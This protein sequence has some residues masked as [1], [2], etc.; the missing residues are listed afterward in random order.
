MAAKDCYTENPEF[1][2]KKEYTE[3][4]DIEQ[5]YEVFIVI[6]KKEL[7]KWQVKEDELKESSRFIFFTKLEK[8][9]KRFKMFGPNYAM[10][11]RIFTDDEELYKLAT[12]NDN[13]VVEDI[14]DSSDEEAST[15]ATVPDNG[16]L[17][18][19]KNIEV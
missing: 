5:L 16:S 4:P 9:Y 14:E 6:Y 18:E 7:P 2:L 8:A 13:I 10:L 12:Q 11:Q 3:K 19:N 1:I 17:K 15:G